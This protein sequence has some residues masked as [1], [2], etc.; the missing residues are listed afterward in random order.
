[1]TKHLHN[2]KAILAAVIL[3]ALT[4]PAANA[5]SR[6]YSIDDLTG[7]TWAPSE[8]MYNA[9]VY[10]T[11]HWIFYRDLL[12]EVN[13]AE[14]KLEKQDANTI[15]VKNAFGGLMDLPFTYN[16]STFTLKTNATAGDYPVYQVTNPASRPDIK[17]IIVSPTY[18][19]R[20]GYSWDY[21]Q[22]TKY[23]HVYHGNGWVSDALEENPGTQDANGN[24]DLYLSFNDNPIEVQVT[25]TSGTTKKIYIDTWQIDFFKPTCS[26]SDIEVKNSTSKV[27]SYK[28][29]FD[30]KSG[31]TFELKNLGGR[32]AGLSPYY[33][34][35]YGTTTIA[36]NIEYPTGSYN[37]ENGTAVLN[38]VRY[39]VEYAAG[40]PLD[41][42]NDG[43]NTPK[44][45]YVKCYYTAEKLAN[46]SYKKNIDG[47]VRMHPDLA[48]H[49]GQTRWVT[50]GGD[51]TTWTR[52]EFSFNDFVA[53]EEDDNSTLDSRVGTIKDTRITPDKEV[54]VT[55]GV[56]ILE[57]RLNVRLENE[58]DAFL[59]ATVPFVITKNEHF[60]TSY[61]VYVVQGRVSSHDQVDM[62]KAK[63]IGT[64]QYDA[65]KRGEYSVEGTFTP[66]VNVKPGE[67]F[68]DDFTFFV[69]AN[70]GRETSAS[71]STKRMAAKLDP[72]HHDLTTVNFSTTTGVNGLINNS[73]S[74]QKT[75]DGIIVNAPENL[76]V[77]VYNMAGIKIAEGV[78]NSE[79]TL[80]A[81]GV[82]MVKAGAKVFKVV[83]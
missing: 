70:Y 14:L 27:R 30:F 40:N 49:R 63:Y 11:N 9:L 34:T 53:L 68:T 50:N 19:K 13:G 60:T 51:C 75:P 61:D 12:V 72:T 45:H 23:S 57:G 80:N 46:G 58:N 4:A 44:D 69:R 25:Y 36:S 18:L 35:N 79:I 7:S 55:L 81:T 31:N 39:T 17:K 71:T 29:E 24:F 56:D 10:T 66:E 32:Y 74:L 64:V 20:N 47:K 43:T 37:L 1:M 54:E 73:L 82:L 59:T 41:L 42:L 48:N 8:S 3:M 15:I 33:T 22:Y 62:S 28:G 2:L 16:G 5:L 76:P 52:L 83:K 65:A 26:I 38:S 78:A 67:T 77:E 21:L 6:S